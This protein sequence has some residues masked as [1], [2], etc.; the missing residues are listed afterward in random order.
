MEVCPPSRLLP[1]HILIHS[2]LAGKS[3]TISMIRGEIRPSHDGKGEIY[4][5][6]ILVATDKKTARSHLGV[7]P[8]HDAMDQLTVVEHLR[9][10]AGVRGVRNAEQNVQALV[11][12]IGLR[13]F[14]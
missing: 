11:T 13:P 12:A 1:S 14:H 6:H 4:I 9:F 10:Y 5:G 3:T 2:F 7:C 8:Q